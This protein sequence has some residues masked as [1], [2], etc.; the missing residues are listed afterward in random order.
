LRGASMP[1]MVFVGHAG[2]GETQGVR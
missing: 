1:S 2:Y